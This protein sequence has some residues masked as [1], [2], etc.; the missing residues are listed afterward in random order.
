MSNKDNL[1]NLRPTLRFLSDATIERIISEARDVLCRLG[2]EIHNET[3]LSMLQDHGAEVDMKANHVLLTDSIIDTALKVTPSSFKLYDVLGNETHDMSENLLNKSF[4]T[5]RN[6]MLLIREEVSLGTFKL[7]KSPFQ[8]DY[9]LESMLS[10]S[11]YQRIYDSGS[12]A[13]FYQ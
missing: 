2:I 4:P 10:D 7:Y 6:L 12:V 13:G 3:V 8:L 9:N 5:G 11:G 1:S